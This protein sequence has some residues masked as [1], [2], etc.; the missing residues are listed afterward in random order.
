MQLAQTPR[1]L[2]PWG[3]VCTCGSG[4]TGGPRGQNS[5]PSMAGT[6]TSKKTALARKMGLRDRCKETGGT[7][8]KVK[9]SAAKQEEE[10]G[11]LC[12][13][14]SHRPLPSPGRVG[15]PEGCGPHG[16]RGAPP[17]QS[18]GH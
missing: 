18:P 6:S 3:F 7:F 12:N 17:R 1:S 14:T 16:P 2:P 15:R 5:P 11:S 13:L 8:W 9:A 4:V 10:G